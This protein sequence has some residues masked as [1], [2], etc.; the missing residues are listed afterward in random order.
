MR[1]FHTPRHHVDMHELT[2]GACIKIAQ[3]QE[4]ERGISEFLRACGCGETHDW[5]VQERYLAVAHYIA[6]NGDEPDFMV[7]ASA[8]FSDYLNDGGMEPSGR[9]IS[10]ATAELAER[11]RA[12]F[13]DLPG[14]T[15]YMLAYMTEATD[16]KAM[17][18]G[19]RK[20]LEMPGSEFEAAYREFFA[21]LS[22]HIFTLRV[23]D[24]GL[25]IAAK[26][27]EGRGDEVPPVARFPA[28]VAIPGI[29]EIIT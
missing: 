15:Y 2:L 21:S 27:K 1:P 7:G 14:A 12:E 24:E 20:F 6:C 18:E 19:I 8:R 9:Y 28:A 26:E 10:G 17:V 23:S 29:I 13:D 4:Y 25:C 22:P 3:I 11:M 16:D 5:S